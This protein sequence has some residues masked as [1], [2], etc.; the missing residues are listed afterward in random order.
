MVLYKRTKCTE[1]INTVKCIDTVKC[2]GTVK[3]HLWRGS[4]AECFVMV[5]VVWAYGSFCLCFVYGIPADLVGVVTVI[6]EN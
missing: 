4:C 2:V 3:P 6:S 1:R 5:E